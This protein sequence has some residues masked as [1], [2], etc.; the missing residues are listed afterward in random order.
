M[1]AENSWVIGR[2]SMP[3]GLE[4]VNGMIGDVLSLSPIDFWPIQNTSSFELLPGAVEVSPYDPS[5]HQNYREVGPFPGT[6]GTLSNKE[7]MTRLY[8]AVGS[9]L[10]PIL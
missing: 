1:R 10:T 2:R 4:S 6:E 9:S 3:L 5:F 7:I 8:K